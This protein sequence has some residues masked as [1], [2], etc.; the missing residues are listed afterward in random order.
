MK[1]W[2]QTYT[3]LK[4]DLDNPTPEMIRFD[5]I[6]HPLSNLARFNGHTKFMYSV[7]QHSVFVARE[8]KKMGGSVEEQLWGLLHDAAEAYVGDVCSP[9]KHLPFMESYRYMEGMIL[10]AIQCRFGLKAGVMHHNEDSEGPS[11]IV[12]NVPE[13]VLEA[14]TMML[15]IEKRDCLK[16]EIKWD[17]ELPDVTKTNTYIG[18]CWQPTTAYKYF[19]EEYNKLIALREKK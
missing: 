6:A 19:C 18:Q 12:I 13:I 17:W 14:D 7:A 4:F 1:N 16:H 15:A 11:M 10:Y 8:I 9:I 2:I 3:G 5:D